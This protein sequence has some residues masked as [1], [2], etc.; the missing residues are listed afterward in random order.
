MCVYTNLSY[1]SI[2]LYP[3]IHIR[4]AANWANENENVQQRRPTGGGMGMM[5]HAHSPTLM[6]EHA[7]SPTLSLTY[8]PTH[9]PSLNSPR[10]STSPIWPKM[11]AGT[12]LTPDAS[13]P[14]VAPQRP[15]PPL[16]PPPQ[17]RQLRREADLKRWFLGFRV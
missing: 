16:P 12:V 14:P 8:L 7:H 17:S 13:A 15:P 5:Q 1:I 6:M 4:G 10:L 2:F 11:T 3:Y 9:P